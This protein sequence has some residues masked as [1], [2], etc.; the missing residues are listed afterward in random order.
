MHKKTILGLVLGLSFL[1]MSCS[2][3][4]HFTSN[5]PVDV[6]VNGKYVGK[7]PYASVRLSDGVWGNPSCQAVTSDNQS[8]PCNIER[9][10]KIGTIIGGLFIWPLL[11]WTYGPE[12]QQFIN[13]PEA[14]HSVQNQN[15]GL[16]TGAYSDTQ[17]PVVQQSAVPQIQGA[18]NSQ[19]VTGQAAYQLQSYTDEMGR[20]YYLDGMNRR[21]YLDRN[22]DPYYLN[23]QGMPFYYTDTGETVLLDP[24]SI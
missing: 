16:E 4:T 19:V 11:L 3:T 22:G 17:Q 5:V 2:T 15:V 8:F 9:E 12:E 6:Y 18:S 24:N 7:T 21:Y 20:T 1:L 10:A 14:D 23:S 13:I